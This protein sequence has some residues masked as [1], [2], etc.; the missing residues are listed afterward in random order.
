VKNPLFS[1]G[2]LSLAIL[3]LLQAAAAPASESRLWEDR[4]EALHRHSGNELLAQLP[5]SRPLVAARATGGNASLPSSLSGRGAAVPPRLRWVTDAVLP[6]GAL[7]SVHLS[8]RMDAPLII[9][10]QDAHDVEEAQQNISKMIEALGKASGSR[11]LV[12]LEGAAGPFALDLFRAHAGDGDFRREL[13][14][15]FVKTGVLGGPEHAAFT[16]EQPP[17]LWG[18]EDWSAYLGNI[19]ALKGSLSGRASLE[20]HLGALRASGDAL[21]DRGYS[22]RMKEFDRRITAYREGKSAIGDYLRFLTQ[23]PPQGRFARFPQIKLMLDA[24]DR[25][26]GLDFNQV[27]ADR[28]LLARRLAANLPPAVLESLIQESLRHRLGQVTYGEYQS[29]LKELASRHGISL[30]EFPSLNDYV[31]YALLAERLDRSALLE[32][33]PALEQSV[34]DLLAVSAVEKRLAAA[35]RNLLLLDKLVSNSFSPAD[36]AAYLRRRP[37]ILRVSADLQEAARGLDE[38]VPPSSPLGFAGSLAPFES[39]CAEALMRNASLVENLLAK[40]K[41][42]RTRSAVLTCGGFHTDGLV[43][44]LK[45]RGASVLVVTPKIATASVDGHRY[46]D[47]FARDPLPLEKL[48][49]GEIVG[50]PTERVGMAQTEKI[51]QTPF[52]RKAFEAA[53]VLLSS[54]R[55]LMAGAKV[56]E[57]NA[58]LAALDRALLFLGGLR[59]RAS[60]VREKAVSFLRGRTEVTVS[61]SDGPGE[62]S[63][64]LPSGTYAFKKKT[65]GPS[66]LLSWARKVGADALSLVGVRRGSTPGDGSFG[67]R[68]QRRLLEKAG[69]KEAAYH[70]ALKLLAYLSGISRE[71]GHEF[72]ESRGPLAEADRERILTSVDE[73]DLQ[74]LSLEEAEAR[75]LAFQA[76][77][78]DVSAGEGYGEALE[79]LSSS[80]SLKSDTTSRPDIE[81]PR[82]AVPPN[83][84]AVAASLRILSRRPYPE[85]VARRLKVYALLAEKLPK[86]ALFDDVRRKIGPRVFDEAS[87]LGEVLSGR[88]L[89]LALTA[90][91]TDDEKVLERSARVKDWDSEARLAVFTA[92]L[93]R[94]FPLPPAKPGSLSRWRQEALS[95]LQQGSHESFAG[96]RRLEISLREGDPSAVEE[97]VKDLDPLDPVQKA[98]V[99][100]YV[101]ETVSGGAGRAVILEALNR[102]LDENP[103][104]LRD[105]GIRARFLKH[106]M[107][108]S[109][110][111]EP[112]RKIGEN[113]RSTKKRL[114][115]RDA[116]RKALGTAR[117]IIHQAGLAKSWRDLVRSFR[118]VDDKEAETARLEETLRRREPQ[119]FARTEEGFLALQSVLD[120]MTQ[121][122]MAFLTKGLF[123]SWWVEVRQDDRL[124]LFTDVLRVERIRHLKVD[125][126]PRTVLWG[127]SNRG[128]RISSYSLNEALPQG[129]TLIPLNTIRDEVVNIVF[130]S[131]RYGSYGGPLAGRDED[132]ARKLMGEGLDAVVPYKHLLDKQSL[133]LSRRLK[134]LLG[135]GDS[136]SGLS[137]SLF[138]GPEEKNLLHVQAIAE[139]RLM[140]FD[141]FLGS[142]AEARKTAGELDENVE[143][144]EAYLA[145]SQEIEALVSGEKNQEGSAPDDL[146]RG[147][148]ARL[149][150]SQLP[151]VDAALLYKSLRDA[152]LEG[153]EDERSQAIGEVLDGLSFRLI[154]KRIK[155]KSVMK[156]ASSSLETISF[157][158]PRQIGEAAKDLFQRQYGPLPVVSSDE[159]DRPRGRLSMPQTRRAGKEWLRKISFGRADFTGVPDTLVPLWAL[160]L[161]DGLFAPVLEHGFFLPLMLSWQEDQAEAIARW[162]LPQEG[163]L[164]ELEEVLLLAGLRRDLQTHYHRARL[165]LLLGTGESV[166]V[167]V[168]GL[169]FF[170]SS[171]VPALLICLMVIFLFIGALVFPIL[172]LD[173]FHLIS[174]GVTNL[175]RPPHLRL[176]APDEPLGPLENTLDKLGAFFR[177]AYLKDHPDLTNSRELETL[178]Q[179]AADHAKGLYGRAILPAEI[180]K[181]RQA[182]DSA[183]KVAEWGG[184][185][186]AV[187]A[188]L[189]QPLFN[190]G[191]S[192]PFPEGFFSKEFEGRVVKL[193]GDWR[194]ASAVPYGPGS[195]GRETA[196]PS[197]EMVVSLLGDERPQDV[198]LLV[199]AEKLSRLWTAG[200]R[201]LAR[202]LDEEINRIYAPLAER[203]GAE[204]V[205][206]QMRDEAY[207]ISDP[208]GYAETRR[209]FKDLTGME[210]EEA[211]QYLKGLSD[212]AEKALKLRFPKE[213]AAGL[214]VRSRVKGLRSFRNKLEDRRMQRSD[215]P[216]R[217]LLGMFIVFPDEFWTG[218]VQAFL[219]DFLASRDEKGVLDE[220]EVDRKRTVEGGYSAR[221]FIFRLPG[222]HARLFLETQVFRNG[223][224]RKKGGFARYKSGLAAHWR[225]K[226]FKNFPGEAFHR[227]IDFSVFDDWE[228]TVRAA[229]ES[230][231]A[232][233]YVAVLD[234]A[235]AVILRLPSDAVKEDV[236]F[237]P[238]IDDAKD[239][240]A[241]LK[242]V[243]NDSGRWIEE[244][245]VRSVENGSILK[246]LH[247]APL[248]MRAKQGSWEQA[249][250]APAQ[251]AWAA[252]EG[253][254]RGPRQWAVRGRRAIGYLDPGKTAGDRDVVEEERRRVLLAKAT[255]LG[256]YPEA[257]GE[258]GALDA[259][260]A[261][262][263]LLAGRA[264]S[265]GLK[266]GRVLE[267]QS[268]LQ[269]HLHVAHGRL[270]DKAPWIVRFDVAA[271]HSHPGVVS[272]VKKVLENTK[273][274]DVE[275]LALK[276]NAFQFSL[277]IVLKGDHSR[278]EALE[279]FDD[280]VKLIE[281]IPDAPVEAEDT[282]NLLMSVSLPSGF[283]IVDKLVDLFSPG[284]LNVNILGFVQEPDPNGREELLFELAVPWRISRRWLKS[285]VEGSLG[286]NGETKAVSGI[287]VEFL[288]NE[289]ENRFPSR[290]PSF[291]G[292]FDLWGPLMSASPKE[293]LLS[294]ARTAL[295]ALP[296]GSSSH[297]VMERAL[298]L[299]EG[300]DLPGGISRLQSLPLL[301]TPA[302]LIRGWLKLFGLEAKGR[303]FEEV[304]KSIDSRLPMPDVSVKILTG[305]VENPERLIF[306]SRHNNRTTV[307]IHRDLLL[308]WEKLGH[309]R[310]GALEAFLMAA[311][312]HEAAEARGRSHKELS[313]LGL[314]EEGVLDLYQLGLP[315]ATIQEVIRRRA[316]LAYEGGVPMSVRSS[317]LTGE[318]KASLSLEA[319][320]PALSPWTH[321]VFL[322]SWQDR[323]GKKA[324]PHLSSGTLLR[325]ASL[326]LRRSDTVV[327]REEILDWV[328][329]GSL[330]ALLLRWQSM[331]RRG[332]DIRGD[333]AEVLRQSLM[334]FVGSK[335]G[336]QSDA[337]SFLPWA[338]RTLGLLHA[339]GGTVF[340]SAGAV[341]DRMTPLPASLRMDFEKMDL[342]W[343]HQA[344]F[345]RGA[346]SLHTQADVLRSGDFLREK[347]RLYNQVRSEAS[348]WALSSA[349]VDRAW[350]N[351]GD[352][353]AVHIPRLMLDP[354][355][356]W[357]SEET[358]QAGLLSSLAARAAADPAKVPRVI[359]FLEGFRTGDV[360]DAKGILEALSRRQALSAPGSWAALQEVSLAVPGDSIP[361]LIERKGKRTRV[362]MDKLYRR[363]K[364]P[365]Q[366]P[367]HF[368]ALERTDLEWVKDNLPMLVLA[369]VLGGD[370][371]RY[372]LPAGFKIQERLRTSA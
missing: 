245:T 75:W 59:V 355:R 363:L 205:S 207:R 76:M 80:L 88:L 330:E 132:A 216:I 300:D 296:S 369:F 213:A 10:I 27:E 55:R 153:G 276:D 43:G 18:I 270:S 343:L 58:R 20:K 67:R 66:G 202:S 291:F 157:F 98:D 269:K 162:H 221:K 284:R 338:H 214:R 99:F 138:L 15:Y 339:L 117:R 180:K 184:G 313:S 34:E 247:R 235:E 241:G 190:G 198:L 35:S 156:E 203:L 310:P 364:I 365:L 331:P 305:P 297:R 237:H 233:K 292:E 8:P 232:Y 295:V 166:Y 52:R 283:P 222:K 208:A 194:R 271:G 78:P 144:V 257:M 277:K 101:L 325:L 70:R 96:K 84:D 316:I 73:E 120:R 323:L 148:L 161:I 212:E 89:I 26:R 53:V 30:G 298:E 11:L 31:E 95:S 37:A 197:M 139:D 204:K 112:V 266:D 173:C 102:L 220:R 337:E 336:A 289:E 334:G 71:D 193:L 315:A 345:G 349:A 41:A 141:N 268:L 147:L 344:V 174:H 155:G 171:S 322:S 2:R 106:G 329:N 175:R 82:D 14:D 87:W 340:Q 56:D 32:E 5:S 104:L 33:L 39:F 209:L 77:N 239:E 219:E 267:A 254:R 333:I 126:A 151:G 29:F 361:G 265:K 105:N 121:E 122:N 351:P 353:I 332:G 165:G 63:V 210:H 51:D 272:N 320:V 311:V 47:V 324:R 176:S 256:F 128:L 103:A 21:K 79:L 3:F 42:E 301:D 188:A 61:K 90:P 368:F 178:I 142:E 69:L 371:V 113:D 246:I 49:D 227:P 65:R 110:R 274:F 234:R 253:K 335:A 116:L 68:L 12:G 115:R 279:S 40:M 359:L 259:F 182:V 287:S 189:Y 143:A 7:R 319:L 260:F 9:H 164:S 133:Y 328:G 140:E 238:Y 341:D 125:G 183:A 185:P 13:A 225:Y 280:A 200:D 152:V 28:A 60:S 48:F 307:W 108:E 64:A 137:S 44:L 229:R 211:G 158:S 92:W 250:T 248:P 286:Q 154:E 224:D 306:V 321:E 346:L 367:L 275:S 17:L 150:V 293:V 258:E 299:L 281:A 127:R 86:D 312:A 357:T 278:A 94:E 22:P 252:S 81:I 57:E 129:L 54:F 93:T 146:K 46:L 354:A 16:A 264:A 314:D 169:N 255:D 261:W 218:D 187:I 230:V 304:L 201:N 302:D 327:P 308:K 352:L 228:A 1:V 217:D 192:V 342:F 196:S 4:R 100:L 236:L 111:F 135:Q 348:R 244:G 350:Q 72:L 145:V 294:V 191:D 24:M 107:N 118:E 370:L 199:F 123:L 177:N 74:A 358:A 240:A 50:I 109:T 288:D 62:A 134:Q 172:C 186:E 226:V 215:E 163:S 83:M 317:V 273:E 114:A 366:T 285:V 372:D 262:L 36:W 159:G 356:P 179:K 347:Y 309:V 38:P 168:M 45:D 249:K 360:S 326:D 206:E 23:V 19:G 85:D 282:R 119:S 263:G 6:F 181:L 223:R 136:H 149:A 318:E 303:G 251:L 124:H 231:L 160:N 97:R 130:P 362:H 91:E 195:K 242:A 290:A 25:E 170:V 131:L 167:L 243:R